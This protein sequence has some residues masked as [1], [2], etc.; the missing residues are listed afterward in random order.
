MSTIKFASRARDI[1]NS[2]SVNEVCKIFESRSHFQIMDDQTMIKRLKREILGLKLRLRKSESGSRVI[3]DEEEHQKLMELKNLQM[4]EMEAKLASYSKL[5]LSGHT[6]IQPIPNLKPDRRRKTVLGS[7]FRRNV[8]SLNREQMLFGMS[9]AAPEEKMSA[10]VDIL[11]AQLDHARKQIKLLSKEKTELDGKFEE[12]VAENSALADEQSILQINI[13]DV[14]SDLSK[15]C[16]MLQDSMEE[17]KA[18]FS[19]HPPVQLQNLQKNNDMLRST[20]SSLENHLKTKEMEFFRL[21]KDLNELKEANQT[22]AVAHSGCSSQ[23]TDLTARLDSERLS[24]ETLLSRIKETENSVVASRNVLMEENSRLKD[25]VLLSAQQHEILSRSLK[26][27]QER[28]TSLQGLL[29]A[30]VIHFFLCCLNLD[31][32]QR[33]NRDVRSLS[34]NWT[35]YL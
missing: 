22:L 4:A 11:Q 27:V 16:D 5:L 3:E 35:R 23:I 24:N 30:V 21:K 7:E 20:I 12:L 34:K 25:Q 26:D 15:I 10:S 9:P 33:L 6:P 18:P 32:N 19:V 2:V 8:E 13:E 28:E 1:K 31:R 29:E 17:L 14:E